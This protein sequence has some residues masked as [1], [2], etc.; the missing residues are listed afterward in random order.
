LLVARCSLLVD[1]FPVLVRALLRRV[2]HAKRTCGPLLFVIEHTPQQPACTGLG[3]RS[4][5][6]TVNRIS[7]YSYASNHASGARDLKLLHRTG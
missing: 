7:R 3:F 1:L 6:V 5:V 2:S 4:V